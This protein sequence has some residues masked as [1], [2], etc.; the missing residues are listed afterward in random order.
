MPKQ[1]KAS[2]AVQW[3]FGKQIEGMEVEK[4]MSEGI[5]LSAFGWIQTPGGSIKVE[6]SDWI[7]TWEDGKKQVVSNEVFKH[8]LSV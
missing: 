2:D 7:I 3:F 1:R 6:H 8:L 5:V 4:V